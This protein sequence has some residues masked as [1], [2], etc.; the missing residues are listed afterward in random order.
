MRNSRI[1]LFLAG[2]AIAAAISHVVWSSLLVGLVKSTY[3]YRLPD[4]RKIND[5]VFNWIPLISIYSQNIAERDSRSIAFIGSSFTF[6]YLQPSSVIFSRALQRL[7]EN[8]RV[9]NLSILGADQT[10]LAVMIGCALADARSDF[11]VVF[12]ELPILNDN[13]QA[14]SV[15]AQGGR[16]SHDFDL[17]NCPRI[18]EHTWLSY[19]LR[20]PYGSQWVSLL[21]DESSKEVPPGRLEF[22]PDFIVS[23]AT[24]DAIADQITNARKDYIRLMSRFAGKTVV[25]P[26]LIQ[27]DALVGSGFDRGNIERQIDDALAACRTIESVIC[28]DTRSMSSRT[29]LFH[30]AAHLNARGHAIFGEWL[31]DRVRPLIGHS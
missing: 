1:P 17:R 21:R 30:D 23:A 28:L 19:F 29:E 24:Y 2:A 11:D 4:L 16:L 10:G 27:I 20:R 5:P 14:R 8:A 22:P 9:G 12:L 25:Y 26:S 3:P 15:A 6:G 31:F 18:G 7:F 13:S